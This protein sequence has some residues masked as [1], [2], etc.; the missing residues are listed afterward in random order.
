M[1]LFW[2]FNLSFGLILRPR[3][4]SIARKRVGRVFPLRPHGKFVFWGS[5]P[6]L[7]IL[8]GTLGFCL[9]NDFYEAIIAG[10]PFCKDARAGPVLVAP[11]E[12]NHGEKVKINIIPSL[13]HIS[14]VGMIILNVLI[15]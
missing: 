8:N 15:L 11:D 13:A 5:I 1:V 6:V 3:K 12:R 7:Q 14:S 4:H 2:T 10:W 9:A